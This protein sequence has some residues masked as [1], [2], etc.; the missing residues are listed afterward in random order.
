[1]EIGTYN[2]TTDVTFA[3]IIQDPEILTGTYLANFLSSP[4]EKGNTGLFASVEISLSTSHWESSR[5]FGKID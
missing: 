3:P 4:F 1:M 2:I 5:S